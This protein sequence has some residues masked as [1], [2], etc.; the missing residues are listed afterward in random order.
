MS[1]RYF[2]RLVLKPCKCSASVHVLCFVNV[3]Q[4]EMVYF[5][6]QITL[7]PTSAI[8]WHRSRLCASIRKFY[9]PA[10]PAPQ[11]RAER[12]PGQPQH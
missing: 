3:M 4:C 5:H 6:H 1:A 10:A 12:T 7:P 9:Y 11:Q 2:Y 8:L